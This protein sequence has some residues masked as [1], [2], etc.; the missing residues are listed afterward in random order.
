MKKNLFTL[1]LLFFSAFVFSQSGNTRYW[2]AFKDKNASPY[3]VGN[4]SQFLSARAISR[5]ALHSY[6][7]TA[8]DIPVNDSY[9]AQV[10]ATGAILISRSRWFNGI[11]VRITDTAQVTAINN[12]SCV[13][14]TKGVALVKQ[15]SP[16]VNIPDENSAHQKNASVQNTNRFNYGNS[17]GQIH[18]LNGEC[19]HDQF[20][21]G[22]GMQIAEID[23]GFLQADTAYVFDSLWMQSRVISKYNFFNGDTSSNL[24]TI[25]GHGTSV[26]SCMAAF[27]SGT[28]IGTAPYAKYYLLRSEV[29]SSE[30]IMEEYSWVSAIEYADSAGAD[31]ATSSLGYTRF[32]NDP[33]MDHTWADLNGRTSLASISATMAARRGM[34]VCIAA[35][36]EGGSNSTWK[37]IS[38]PADADSIITVGAVDNGGA[39]AGFSSVGNTSDGRIKPDVMA[40]GQGSTIYSTYTGA[41][42]TGSGTSFATPILAGMVACLWQG[43]PTKKN[44]EIIDAIKKSSSQFA[45]PDS[46]MGYGIPDFCV[47]DQILKGTY[48]TEVHLPPSIGENQSTVIITGANDLQLTLEMFDV[49]GKLLASGPA[50][51]LKDNGVKQA[52]EIPNA[53]TLPTGIYLVKISSNDGR[54]WV[55]KLLR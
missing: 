14:S 40:W 49:T 37:K 11:V 29:D 20:Y 30:K 54:H 24:F 46:L 41:V 32:P 51:I 1:S 42:G 3:S 18:Q 16:T 21:D 50:K 19:L 55:T 38:I 22:T 26:L 10:K 5:R 44:M 9:I 34:I 23:D 8:E 43:N 12:L 53:T 35:G 4:P 28:F 6:A 48:A 7:V 15:L 31:V 17:Y 2:V 39:K 25:G 45:T 47:A 13:Q 27:K 33:S 36:N 52:I